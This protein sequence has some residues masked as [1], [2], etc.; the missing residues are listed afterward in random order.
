MRVVL[1]LLA[2]ALAAGAA[3]AADEPARAKPWSD[4]AE[5]GIIMTSG[6]SEG[7]NF[8]LSNKFKYTW[9]NAELTCDAAALRTESRTRTISNPAPYGTAVVTDTTETTAATYGIAAKYR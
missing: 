2:A 7:T 5:F 9:S 4:A 3:I 8:S 6:N 1:V